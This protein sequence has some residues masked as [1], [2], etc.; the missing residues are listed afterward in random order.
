MCAVDTL[1]RPQDQA[2]RPVREINLGGGPP[3]QCPKSNPVYP[4][5]GAKTE[6]IATG[7]R[8]GGVSLTL[9]YNTMGM[10]PF[11]TVRD[12]SNLDYPQGFGDLWFSS[13]H[14]KLF[15]WSNSSAAVLSRGDGIL[16]NFTGSG[17]AY[18]PVPGNNNQLATSGGGFVFTDTQT[19]QLE[20]YNSAGNVT[21]ISSPD[22]NTLSFTYGSGGELSSV[23]SAIDGRVLRFKYYSGRVR[24]IIAADSSVIT[25][26]YDSSRNLTAL[27]WQDGRV[28][29]FNY[30][31]AAHPWALTGKTDENN[32]RW[33]TFTYDQFGRATSSELAGGVNRHQFDYAMQPLPISTL[34]YSYADDVFYRTYGWTSSGGSTGMTAPGG[35]GVA[36]NSQIVA[37]VPATTSESQP[38]GSGCAAASR[39]TT[40]DAN[41][42]ILSQDDFDGFRTCFAYDSSNRQITR[43]EG[44]MTTDVCTTVLSGSVPSYARKITTS[45]HP[46]WRREVAVIRPLNKTT[47]VYHGQPD[48]F[49]GNVPANCTSASAMPNGKPLPLMCKKV[50]QALLADNSVDSSISARTT[51]F[52]YDTAGRVTSSVDPAG[53]TT[54][55]TYYGTTTFTTSA[56]ASMDNVALLLHGAGTNGSTSAIDSALFK[57]QMSP[58]GG[59]QISSAQSKWGT[60]SLA[61]AATGD[62]FSTPADPD[63]FFE[64]GDFTVEAWIYLNDNGGSH[65]KLVA[66]LYRYGLDSLWLVAVNLDGKLQFYNKDAVSVIGTTVLAVNTWHHVAVSR[67]GTTLRLFLNGAMEATG[68]DASDYFDY[69]HPFSV[70]GDAT[71]SAATQLLGFVEDL[72]VT[73]GVARYTAAFSTPSTSFPNPGPTS[74]DT[75]N[76]VGDPHTTTNAVGHVSTYVKH[77]PTGRAREMTDPN[78]V[79]TAITYTPRGFIHTVTVTPDQQAPRTTTFEY[80]NAGQLTSVSMPDATSL[81]YSYD[82]AH[83]LTS[84]TDERGNSL[85]YTFDT[86]GNRIGEELRDSGGTL[87]QSINRSFDALNRVQQ[88]IGAPQ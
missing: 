54:T 18:T 47:T 8:I 79:K 23:S 21:S 71:G 86:S 7:M 36:M 42:N 49:N 66:G 29:S 38:A 28:F 53:K 50:E 46:D 2:C 75:G 88:I 81:S 16:L 39:N 41:A 61:F 80:D 45:W 22:G 33:A 73:K 24:H 58:S 30:E 56:D 17:G 78:K 19:G 62:R 20:Y 57:K 64:T 60:T 32:S 51:A 52:A 9:A 77:D 87:R 82:A 5:S 35:W 14:R 15:V 70:G 37:G 68:T 1:P 34:T 55:F 84:I 11:A 69:P 26:T 48:P 67:S 74:S 3:L 27:T 63:F 44:L 40:W 4:L 25:A 6:S 13:L 76:T 83:R 85:T 10:L 72:R 12:G 43:I 31:N 59:A 65:S